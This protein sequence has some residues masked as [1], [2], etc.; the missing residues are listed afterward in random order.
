MVPQELRLRFLPY[1]AFRA[2]AFRFAGDSA[3]ARVVA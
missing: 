1:L 3:A 2:M